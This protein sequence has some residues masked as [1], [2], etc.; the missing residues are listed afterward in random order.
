M[1]AQLLDS[2]IFL[3][4]TRRIRVRIL[5]VA[6]TRSTSEPADPFSLV[7]QAGHLW[8]GRILREPGEI[9]PLGGEIKIRHN[10][11]YHG[12]SILGLYAII[13]PTIPIPL[14]PSS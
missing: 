7:A 13:G 12:F 4:K 2:I 1:S 3:F 8:G 9:S 10:S 11:G 6:L 5:V 14:P